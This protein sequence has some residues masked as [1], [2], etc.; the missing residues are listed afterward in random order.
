MTYE[1]EAFFSY[2]RDPQT[3]NWHEKVKEKLEFWLRMELNVP[4]GRLFFDRTAIRSGMEWRRKLGDSLKR[5][6]CIICIWSPCYFQSQWCMSE[7]KTFRARENACG[8]D[9]ILPA[10]IH[11][12]DY[13]PNEAKSKQY[14]DFSEY[15]ST[16]RTFWETE[17]A[18]EFEHQ[19]LK[20]FARDL[21]A[22]IRNTPPYS[23]NFPL[24]ESPE[25][26]IEEEE[27]IGRPANT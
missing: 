17:R 3:D 25:S 1:Y 26:E 9:L 14:D 24:V 2:K 7:W 21:A 8:V 18:D 23:D 13:F 27:T 4:L 15:T 5:S 12:G 11:D 22:L 6:K 16:I 19:K 10:T 20:S